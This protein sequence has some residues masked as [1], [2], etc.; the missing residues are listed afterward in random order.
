MTPVRLGNEKIATTI[1]RGGSNMTCIVVRAE[2]YRATT[3]SVC[4]STDT[5]AEQL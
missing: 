1:M 3:A 5:A 4:S 2:L